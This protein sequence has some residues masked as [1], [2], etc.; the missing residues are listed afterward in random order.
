[1]LSITVVSARV[2]AVGLL[3]ALI[4]VVAD[5]A[6][7]IVCPGTYKGHLQGVATDAG[8]DTGASAIYWSF[9]VTLVKTDLKGEILN[10]VEVPNHHGDLAWHDG[11]VYVAVNLGK[12]NEEPGQAD[13]W[14]YVYDANDLSLLSKH[15]VQEVVHGAGGM[16]YRDGHFFVVGG[17]PEGYNENYVYEYDGDFKF[18]ERHVIASGWT[19][20]GIQTTAFFD[21]FWWFGCYG[22]PRVLLKADENFQFL[23]KYVEDWSIGIAP[24]SA[25]QCLRGLTTKDE[26][27]KLWDGSVVADTPGRTEGQSKPAP[28]KQG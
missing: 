6:D 25:E 21:G 20:L 11:K 7:P 17:L 8:S 3:L 23:E 15:E 28:E 5:A 19:K 18:I 4:S 2:L 24:L 13:S 16:E 22:D 27:S 1:M 9:T 10:Q 12:F 26:A 14:V